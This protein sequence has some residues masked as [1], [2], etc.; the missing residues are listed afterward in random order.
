[1]DKDQRLIFF[2]GNL[3]VNIDPIGFLKRYKNHT[4]TSTPKS[5]LNE[6]IKGF[7]NSARD[8][9][10]V[11]WVGI[12][13]GFDEN[14]RNSTIIYVQEV[15]NYPSDLRSKKAW[16]A[17]YKSFSELSYLMEP[18]VITTLR[19]LNPNETPD[20]IK[21]RLSDPESPYQ[22]FYEDNLSR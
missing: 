6:A 20:Q 22:I 21:E 11:S 7:F 17:A 18:E 3:P 9:G 2:D 13:K 8:S 12:T 1:M 19:F 14:Q 4:P 10:R 16:M 15:K 5:E